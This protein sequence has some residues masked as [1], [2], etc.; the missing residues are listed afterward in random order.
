VIVY[1][2]VLPELPVLL[3][4]WL[5]DV[6]EP[7]EAPEIPDPFEAVHEKVV[8]AVKLLKLIAVLAPEQIVELTGVAVANGTGFTVMITGTDGPLHPLAV[9]TI[10]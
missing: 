1:V 6:P 10:L 3:R 9:G 8:P 2:A 5:I 4:I 7:A